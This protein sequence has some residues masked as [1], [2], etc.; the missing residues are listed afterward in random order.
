MG[1][2]VTI[3]VNS[4]MGSWVTSVTIISV[5]RS[6]AI[7]VTIIS[8]M[9]WQSAENETFQRH[10]GIQRPKVRGQRERLERNIVKT[11]SLSGSRSCACHRHRS[12]VMSVISRKSPPPVRLSCLL[13][14]VMARHPSPSYKGGRGSTSSLLQFM[15]GRAS[16]TPLGNQEY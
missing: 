5:M 14:M 8:F 7:P 15:R 3:T 11:L 16:Q 9:G 2:P 10:L 1:Q 6:W 4:V 12:P 13:G